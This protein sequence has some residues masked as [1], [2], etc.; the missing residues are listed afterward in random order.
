MEEDLAK[1]LQIFLLWN[2]ARQEEKSILD[3]I[4]KKYEVLR[5]FEIHWPEASFPNNFTR[6][7]NKNMRGGFHKTYE[8]GRGKFLLITAWDKSPVYKLNPRRGY[9]I[10]DNAIRNKNLYRQWTGGGFRVHASDNLAE[11]D[12]NLLLTL[13]IN[14]LEFEEKYTTPWD[15]KIIEIDKP[16]PG[17]K[18]WKHTEE[19]FNFAHR[20][21]EITKLRLQDNTLELC[22]S[23]MQKIRRFL[24]LRKPLFCFRPNTYYTRVGGKKL[25]VILKN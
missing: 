25:K 4:K 22:C 24:N 11:V 6:F 19:L 8:C 3:D 18:S 9:E 12:E 15:G 5:I 1:E 23:D 17:Y 20:I 16:M 13:G 2:K 10:N 14:R 21:K 7:Y